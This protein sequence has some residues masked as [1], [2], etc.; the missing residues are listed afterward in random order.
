L[1][2]LNRKPRCA[3]QEMNTSGLFALP[4]AISLE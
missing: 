4:I 2:G 3:H 1:P